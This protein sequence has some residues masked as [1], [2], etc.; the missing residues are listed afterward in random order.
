MRG[1]VSLRSHNFSY[2]KLFLQNQKR[3]NIADFPKLRQDELYSQGD[4]SSL[5]FFT[6]SWPHRSNGAGNSVTLLREYNDHT[7]LDI[8]ASLGGLWTFGNGIF[9]LIFGG[10]LLYFLLGIKPLSRFGLVHFIFGKRIREATQ[11]TYPRFYE[12]GG[13]PGESDAGV[14]AFIR[15]HLLGV[16]SNDEEEKQRQQHKD[17]D[18]FGISRPSL[19]FTTNLQNESEQSL[20]MTMTRSDNAL[21]PISLTPSRYRFSS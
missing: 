14:V 18:N 19:S 13:Q 15:E 11:K 5:R 10:S 3:I 4:I 12:E 17:L 20:D 16:L 1:C 9:A 7:F 6:V 2:R 8:L 21:I